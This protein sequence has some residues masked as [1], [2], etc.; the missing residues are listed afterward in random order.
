MAINNPI[1]SRVLTGVAS[2]IESYGQDPDS[3]AE[4][5]GIEAA[6]LYQPDIMISAIAIND[7]LE[8]AALACNDRFFCLRLASLQSWKVLG[9][10]IWRLM[11]KAGN[12]GEMLQILNDNLE[13]HSD[14]MS[15]YLHWD[16]SGGAVFS[17]EIRSL[18]VSC[19]PLHSNRA[20]AIE[21]SLGVTCFE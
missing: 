4:G 14:A 11:S 9:P 21:L 8:Q 16:D 20:Q 17:I 2:L 15:N 3:I 12:V 7:L 1:P 5:V 6:A 18:A 19:K 10:S 13:R